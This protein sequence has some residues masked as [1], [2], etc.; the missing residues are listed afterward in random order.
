M[1]FIF[2]GKLLGIVG[3]FLAFDKYKRNCTQNTTFVFK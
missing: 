2:L 1:T 3:Y